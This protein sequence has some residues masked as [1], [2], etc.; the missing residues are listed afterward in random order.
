MR[1]RSHTFPSI[2]IDD[3]HIRLRREAT[4]K[5]PDD[6]IGYFVRYDTI[7]R[8]LR[9]KTISVHEPGVIGR[10]CSRVKESRYISIGGELLRTLKQQ[11][12]CEMTGEWDE[13]EH[14]F[15]FE[16]VVATRSSAV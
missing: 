6:F 12:I 8:V 2:V 14:E 3:N 16:S 4:D 13:D 15:T 5:L 10:V 9:V 7:N 11:G 1:G